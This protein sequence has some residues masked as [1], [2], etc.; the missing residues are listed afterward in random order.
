MLN[1]FKY[2]YISP[3]RTTFPILMVTEV[4]DETFESF[5]ADNKHA[6][7]DCWAAW[8]GPCRMLSP[9]IEELS[10]ERGEVA[11]GKLDVDQNRSTPTK[12]GIMSIPTILYFKDGKLVNKTIGAYPKSA[13][14]E[15]IDK[16][17]A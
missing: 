12:Y 8:C 5:V 11:F 13:L 17:T 9:V 2:L 10:Q 6:V 14:E 7:I 16:L 1:I 3:E 15:H 4:N